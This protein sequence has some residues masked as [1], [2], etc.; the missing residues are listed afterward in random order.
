[1]RADAKPLDRPLV[2][3]GGYHD[4]GIGAALL[5]WE[6]DPLIAD[7]RV[8]AVC[9]LSEPTFDD[10]RRS[11]IKAVERAFPSDDPSRTTEVDVI[12][13]SM[14]GLAARYAALP[15]PG[16]RALRIARL[17]TVSSPLSGAELAKLP[18]GD[19][20]QID[21]RIGSSFL[22][23]FNAPATTQPAVQS[24]ELIPYVRLHDA[25]VGARHAGPIGRPAWWVP[26]H[27]LEPSH[28]LSCL[29]DRIVADIARRLRDEPPFTT[30][31]PAP[32]PGG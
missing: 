11:I 20:K 6:L 23:Q 14:G 24:Y 29:D 28:G 17:F 4:P 30:E 16:E 10:C 3:V 8:I 32:V 5:R 12:G 18:T 26:D 9:L 15:K 21:M 25:I 1:M 13:I 31:P 27:P 22:R 2:L 7:R 19:S